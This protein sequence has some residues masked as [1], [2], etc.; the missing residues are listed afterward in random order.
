MVKKSIDG[1]IFEVK[2]YECSVHMFDGRTIIGKI[3]INPMGRLSDVFTQ[4]QAP[5]VVVYEAT[6][7]DGP[8]NRT[9]I[10]NKSGISW[11]EPEDPVEAPEEE[12]VEAKDR[13]T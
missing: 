6:I 5:F 11:V 12:P 13:Q 8:R 3:N 7:G 9:F 10:L 4:G 1:T 2:E